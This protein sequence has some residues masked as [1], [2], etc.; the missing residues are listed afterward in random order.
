[1][2]II[3]AVC[4]GVAVL[5]GGPKL[6]NAVSCFTDEEEILSGVLADMPFS[7]ETK[8]RS[9]G[10]DIEKAA[11]WQ[12]KVVVSSNGRVITG[13]N[14]ASARTVAQ[15]IMLRLNFRWECQQWRI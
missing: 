2:K 5:T 1:V 11:P 14:P 6:C 4:H 12:P 9:I 15:Q 3:G 13:Q 7:L 10:Y 8:L